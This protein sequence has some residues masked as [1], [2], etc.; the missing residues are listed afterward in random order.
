[1]KLKKSEQDHIKACKNWNEALAAT[2][3]VVRTD[4]RLVGLDKIRVPLAYHAALEA[5]NCPDHPC[6]FVVPKEAGPPHRGIQE[7]VDH[8]FAAAVEIARVKIGA[9]A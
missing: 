5:T 1:M 4:P 8:C 2:T 7:I 3:M 6:G 9:V